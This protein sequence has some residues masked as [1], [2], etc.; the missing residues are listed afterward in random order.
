MKL[1][2]T[3]GV[4]VNAAK[5][6][7]KTAYRKMAKKHHPDKG[8]DEAMFKEIQKAYD[9]LG[10]DAKRDHY[11]KTGDDNHVKDDPDRILMAIFAAI[12]D[13]GD[14]HGNIID[15]ISDKIHLE[16]S[17][18]IARREKGIKESVKLSRILER[19]STD[20]E[21]LFEM[22]LNASIDKISRSIDSIDKELE[23]MNEMLGRLASYSD[24]KPEAQQQPAG[25]DALAA[26]MQSQANGPF[27]RSR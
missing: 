20:G 21:N 27:G 9:V 12:I 17:N 11:D 16:I 18:L 23:Q 19:I 25:L 26:M 4:A 14:F 15:R 22:V 24:D 13:S 1:Y 2:E 8:G 5:L 6:E 3:L 10:D 7:I